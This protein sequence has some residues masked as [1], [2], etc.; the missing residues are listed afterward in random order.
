MSIIS[1]SIISFVFNKRNMTNTKNVHIITKVGSSPSIPTTKEES[2]GGKKPLK[3]ILKK[4][5]R[6]K[7]VRDPAKP[8]P[9][10]PGMKRHTLKLLTSKGHKKLKKT[11]RKKLHKL[12]KSE[13]DKL[14]QD[15]NMKLNPNTPPEIARKIVSNAI[16]AGFVSSP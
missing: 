2:V 9:L 1:K 5:Q 4:T 15:S 8:T 14:V 12:K 11:L 13:L 10:K 6:I 16:S 3:S 7:D